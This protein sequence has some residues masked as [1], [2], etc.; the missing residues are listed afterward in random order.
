MADPSVQIEMDCCGLSHGVDYLEVMV[1]CDDS[2]A[3][4][5]LVPSLET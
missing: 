1:T 3:V 5:A 4:A 2:E